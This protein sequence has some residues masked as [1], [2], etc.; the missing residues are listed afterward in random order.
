[1]SPLLLAKASV[2]VALSF[3]LFLAF[4]WK[5]LRS[6]RLRIPVERKPLSLTMAF[7][8]AAIFLVVNLLLGW[9]SG[10]YPGLVYVSALLGGLVSSTSV[11]ASVA[12]LFATGALTAK[13]AVTCFFLGSLGSMC[14]KA[15][16]LSWKSGLRGSRMAEPFVIL[17][18]AWLAG[19]A[20]T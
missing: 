17:L 12:Y 10:N 20:L 3:V 1:V 13:A 11:Y 7:E 5:R 16:Y 4:A 8:F 9:V 19:Y 14:A 2:F 18:L 6:K 15:A